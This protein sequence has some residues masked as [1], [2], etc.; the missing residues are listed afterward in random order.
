MA[1]AERAGV[2]YKTSPDFLAAGSDA[3]PFTKAGLMTPADNRLASYF[4][5]IRM[6]SVPMTGIPL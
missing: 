6:L 4:L 1:A 2:S 3:A 5:L